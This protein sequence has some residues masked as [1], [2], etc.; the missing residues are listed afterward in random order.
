MKKRVFCPFFSLFPLFFPK[1]CGNLLI[2]KNKKMEEPKVCEC[3]KCSERAKKEAEH[4]EMTMAV[5]LAMVPMVVITLFGQIG[6]F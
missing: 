5:L 3:P 6:L 1:R 4:E 2:I